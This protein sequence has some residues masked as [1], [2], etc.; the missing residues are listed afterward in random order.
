MSKSG[1]QSVMLP[2]LVPRSFKGSAAL[3]IVAG[4]DGVE[5]KRVVKLRLPE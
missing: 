2:W 5:V 4:K 3:M 1:R